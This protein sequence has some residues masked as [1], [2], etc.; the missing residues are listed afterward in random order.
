MEYVA[1][2]VE[3]CFAVGVSGAVLERRQD[4]VHYTR[5]TAAHLTRTVS[6]PNGASQLAKSA[7]FQDK[8][9]ISVSKELCLRKLTI[10]VLQ[11]PRAAEFLSQG[12]PPARI[13]HN[14]LR[15]TRL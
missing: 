4:K 9:R 8:F 1:R 10:G 13:E 15:L 2:R 14:G 5:N 3:V 6:F 11:S 7:D 12:L